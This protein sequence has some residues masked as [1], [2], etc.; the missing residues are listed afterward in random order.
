[1]TEEECEYCAQPAG[2][3]RVVE[4][5]MEAEVKVLSA[6]F[7]VIDPARLV[8]C[9]DEC[10][11]KWHGLRRKALWQAHQVRSNGL[12]CLCIECAGKG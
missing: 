8:F 10:R 6:F 9:D 12:G 7:W 5:P 11:T 2:K 3:R 1:M 4:R